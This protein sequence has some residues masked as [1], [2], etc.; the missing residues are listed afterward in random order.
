[1]LMGTA[2]FIVIN[3]ALSLMGTRLSLGLLIL[4]TSLQ[5]LGTVWLDQ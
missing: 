1:M 5:I 2:L 3:G 4:L